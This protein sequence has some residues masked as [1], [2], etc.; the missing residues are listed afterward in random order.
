MWKIFESKINGDLSE[1][2]K[3]LE[4]YKQ[5]VEKQLR[6]TLFKS[7]AIW[8]TITIT[9][10]LLNIA[11]ITLASYILKVDIEQHGVTSK[12]IPTI[13]LAALTIFS[14]VITTTIAIY[15]G[16]MRAKVYNKA[17]QFIQAETLKWAKKEGD[18]KGKNKDEI[19]ENK[20]KDIVEATKKVKR[21]ISVKRTFAQIITGGTYE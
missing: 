12:T 13:A 3:S 21:S 7:K 14:F 11:L 8:A 5:D 15:Q 10:A 6:R 1:E 4:D 17:T 20:I 2:F 19:F 16:L 18:Y 9:I